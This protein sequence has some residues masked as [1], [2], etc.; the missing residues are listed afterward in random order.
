MK[1]PSL[2]ILMI[3]LTLIALIPL[4]NVEASTPIMYVNPQISTVEILTTF[5]INI[6]V[7]QVVDLAAWEFKLYYP[8]K[9]LNATQ[10]QE[11]SFLK[12]AGQT[13]FF[14]KELTD[15]YNETHGVIWAFCTLIGQGP[16]A[17]GNGTLA[18]ITF[19]AKFVGV[20]TLKLAETDML[21]SQMPP[22]HISHI[23]ED[24]T[25]NI[26]GHDIAVI[27]VSSLKTIVGQGCT[28]NI[29]VTV[30]NQGAFAE[31]FNLTL[32]ANTTSIETKEITL[33]NNASTTVTFTWNTTGFVKGNYTIRAYAHPVLG[34][35]DTADNSLVMSS[36]ISVVMPGDANLDGV[37]TILDV[38]KVTGIYG[39]KKGDQNYN[40]NVDWDND[41]RITI[42]DVTIVT[43]R[44]GQRDP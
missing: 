37:I 12:T 10:I 30:I 3:I 20:A 15:N 43:G 11:G 38:C 2:L 42:L 29:N 17:T 4:G 39:A 9:Y 25:V 40:P 21:D 8:N 24:G 23:T 14:V 7:S 1:K 5:Q 36:V 22:N 32:Y 6:S 16:G 18:T 31:T 44:Y 34:E 35:T 28:M 26:I 13:S 19:K 33:N 41:Q 27:N